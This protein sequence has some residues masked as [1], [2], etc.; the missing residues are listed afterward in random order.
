MCMHVSCKSYAPKSKLHLF[1]MHILCWQ[2][3]TI[4]GCIYTSWCINNS[5][6]T[7]L[8]SHSPPAYIRVVHGSDG[9][10]DNSGLY[11]YSIWSDW[12][13]LS[14]K[15]I[16]FA[17]NGS[18]FILSSREVNWC[19]NCWMTVSGINQSWI[20]V[21]GCVRKEDEWALMSKAYQS[22]AHKLIRYCKQT[23]MCNLAPLMNS[24]DHVHPVRAS[25]MIGLEL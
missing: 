25:N 6:I 9:P 17:R 3:V 22:M 10:A 23:V 12:S 15:Y 13:V 2:K 18:L 4:S 11:T 8:L 16:I 7:D 20:S 24:W 21:P 14:E 19:W 5:A 1:R